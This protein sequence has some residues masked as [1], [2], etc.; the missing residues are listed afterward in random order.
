MFC[1]NFNEIALFYSVI[2]SRVKADYVSL[3][4]TRILTISKLTR[5]FELACN[6]MYDVEFYNVEKNNAVDDARILS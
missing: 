2:V 4:A 1:H 3:T 6:I 5:S